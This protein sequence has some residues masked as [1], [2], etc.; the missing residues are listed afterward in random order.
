M[1]GP[2]TKPVNVLR[3][4]LL[5][6]LSVSIITAAKLAVPGI[7]LPQYVTFLNIFEEIVLAPDPLN[8]MNGPVY[9][10]APVKVLFSTFNIPLVL[11]MAAPLSY[12][13]PLNIEFITVVEV[14]DALMNVNS[15]YVDVTALRSL[16]VQLS[17][18]RL[19]PITSIR[20]VAL[21][22]ATL[23]NVSQRSTSLVPLNTNIES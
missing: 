14:P 7:R 8:L 9:A 11:L 10:T 4:I 2:F 15:G 5:T 19:P 22:Y 16:K 3:L 1:P 6:E 21:D 18:V 23:T 17:T 12:Q 13:F 20:T